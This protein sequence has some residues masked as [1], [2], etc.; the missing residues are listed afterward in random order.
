M[1][2]LK[3]PAAG[4]MWSSLLNFQKRGNC[5]IPTLTEVWFPASFKHCWWTGWTSSI[6]ALQFIPLRKK[7]IKPKVLFWTLWCSKGLFLTS[8]IAFCICFTSHF[9]SLTS[10][11]YEKSWL[12]FSRLMNSEDSLRNLCCRGYLWRS[13]KQKCLKKQHSTTLFKINEKRKGIWTSM[14]TSKWLSSSG[15]FHYSLL[16]SQELLSWAYCSTSLKS[17]PISSN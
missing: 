11:G 15:M 13:K 10:L 3:A 14:T 9:W 8:W 1:W 12:H 2:T 5:L 6:A 17:D 16:L 4:F 7:T